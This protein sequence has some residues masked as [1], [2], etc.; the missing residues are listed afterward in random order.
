MD[1]A[2]DRSLAAGR[3]RRPDRLHGRRLPPAPAGSRGSSRTSARARGVVAGLI[4][5]DPD[6][7]QRLAPEVLAPARAR[8]GAAAG[9]RAPDAIAGAAPPSLRRRVDRR[10]RRPSTAPS[11]A[12]SR[13]PRSRTPRSRSAWPMHG[14]PV[15]RAADVARPHLG[16]RATGRARRG[17]SVD[18]AVSTW[19]EAPLRCRRRSRR[20]RLRR[21]KRGLRSPWS[22]RPR[23]APTTF[24]RRARA[25]RSVR[26]ATPGVDRRSASSSTPIRRMAPPRSRRAAG[27][28]VI[29]A[30]RRARRVRAG[31]RQGRCDVARARRDRR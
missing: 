21:H 31:A 11:A 9:A 12:S 26:S 13:W 15:L 10:H 1:L 29:A 22:S 6:E 5:L 17:L 24:A 4:E 27:A 20:E 3:D 16:A 2:A 7:A 23:S 28:R 25:T 8:R 30:G 19:A 18:L 14:V